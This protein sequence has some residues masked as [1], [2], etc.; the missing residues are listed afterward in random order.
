MLLLF[1]V[2]ESGRDKGEEE[3]ELR[4]DG[5]CGF[6]C[7][8]CWEEGDDR[9]EALFSQPEDTVLSFL[10]GLLS[11][12]LVLFLLTLLESVFDD[13]ASATFSVVS[14]SFLVSEVSLP[15]MFCAPPT[16]RMT[17]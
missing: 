1:F 13:V 7:C 14:P 15:L 8:G 16:Y 12:E 2:P 3:G 11:P 17:V 6:C 10:S 4:V 9:S 5:S